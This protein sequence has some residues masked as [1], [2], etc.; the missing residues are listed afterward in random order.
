MK[1]ELPQKLAAARS[2][3]LKLCLLLSVEDTDD[4]QRTD[5]QRD[6]DRKCDPCISDE[7]CN[8]V[9]D[10]GNCSNC[11]R[12]RKLCGNVVDVVGLRTC[13]C[14]DGGIGDGKG[15]G[16]RAGSIGEG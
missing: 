16:H 6:R 11:D 10:K 7:A 2:T 13:R 1:K 5:H 14:H 12:V 9:G 8:D 15:A 4:E 3:V